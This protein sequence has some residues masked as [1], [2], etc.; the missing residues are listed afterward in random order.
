M[1]SCVNRQTSSLVVC[2]QIG[3]AGTTRQCL[4]ANH[5]QNVQ[6]PS[7]KPCIYTGPL[8]P[9]SVFAPSFSSQA[10][11]WGTNTAQ[12]VNAGSSLCLTAGLPNIGYTPGAWKTNNGTL[13]HE[14]WMGDL[15]PLN[16]VPRRVVALFNKGGSP[17]VLF[18][19]LSLFARGIDSSDISRVAVRDVVNHKDMP[20]SADNAIEVTV[21]RHGVALFVVTF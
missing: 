7:V 12:L 6:K 8:P 21:P 17:E 13:E 18:A 19:P 10:Y 14:V 5:N 4:T 2:S 15:T 1:L 11:V 16:G 20:L 9:A 3:Q